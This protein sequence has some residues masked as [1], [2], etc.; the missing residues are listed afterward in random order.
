MYRLTHGFKLVHTVLINIQYNNNYYQDFFRFTTPT[1]TLNQNRDS[2]MIIIVGALSSVV[3]ADTN[4][5]L[6]ELYNNTSRTNDVTN[7][8]GL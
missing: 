8:H 6:K 3:S 7:Y 1:Y 5:L 4:L 2:V